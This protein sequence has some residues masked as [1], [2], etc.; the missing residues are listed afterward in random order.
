[1]SF[2]FLFFIQYYGFFDKTLKIKVYDDFKY[3][4][5]FFTILFFKRTKNVHGQSSIS[6]IN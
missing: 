1:M 5:Q 2:L 3:F 4:L 6:G